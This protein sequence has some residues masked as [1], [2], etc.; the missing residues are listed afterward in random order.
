ML[1]SKFFK[2]DT[3]INAMFQVYSLAS[4]EQCSQT[5]I[6]ASIFEYHN[7]MNYTTKHSPLN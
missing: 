4:V 7:T 5:A 1:C 2:Y 3:Q 6:L